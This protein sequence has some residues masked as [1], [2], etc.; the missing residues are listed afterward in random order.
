MFDKRMFKNLDYM[1]IIIIML[2]VGIGL[3]SIGLAT[4]SPVEDTEDIT[5]ALESFNFR[6][7]KLQLIWFG[8]GIILMIIT[9]CIDYHFLSNVSPYLYWGVVG[10]LVLVMFAGT[11]GGGAQRWIAIGPF[12]L[13]PSEFTKLALILSMARVI[14]K[15][16][17]QGINNVKSLALVVFTLGV[18]FLL[19]AAQ[20]DLGTSIALIAITLGMLFVAGISYKLLL[21]GGAAIAAAIPAAW[22]FLL[23]EYQK[24]RIMV[25]LN[26]E[27]DP[28]GDGLNVLQ[29][30]MSVGSGQ[31]WGQ[32]KNG[33]LFSAN[34]LSQLNYLPAKDTD[35]IFSV[36]AEAFGFVGGITIIALFFLLIIRTIRIGSKAADKLGA[37][38]AIGVASMTLFH[39]YEN[40]GMTMGIMPVTGIP[41][42]FMSYG[43]SSM[44]ANMIAY[45]L[46]LNVGMR[47]QKHRFIGGQY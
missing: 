31:I 35:F 6:Q 21:A 12:R 20:P 36:A 19:I 2:I 13:Q 10:L 40:I 28:L 30:I 45:G 14:S 15:R 47:R 9:A 46:V 4:R 33:A 32:L 23:K 18:P 1:I 24:K 27:L 7:V 5:G 37:L 44:W 41:L 17:E 22:F 39:V 11:T 42:P 34:T 8:T 3:I 25:F 38:I 26:P 29:S 43:G 16:E